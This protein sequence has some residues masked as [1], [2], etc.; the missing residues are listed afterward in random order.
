MILF[1]V[2]LL[3][4]L[5]SKGSAYVLREDGVEANPDENFARESEFRNSPCNIYLY[6]CHLTSV[7]FT[8]YTCSH[9]GKIQYD[10]EAT[11]HYLHH[12]ILSTTIL[13]RFPPHYV[14]ALFYRYS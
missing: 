2:I 1:K 5:F 9:A 14:T 12:S 11:N 3:F 10:T 7:F 13:I 4:Y 8:S 6:H